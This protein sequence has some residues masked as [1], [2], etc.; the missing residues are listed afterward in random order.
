[1][2]TKVM[3]IAGDKLEGGSSRIDIGLGLELSDNGGI[4]PLLKLR[5]R[6]IVL[7]RTPAERPVAVV[8]VRREPLSTWPADSVGARC[9][10]AP[11]C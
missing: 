3:P 1:M 2:P 6:F 9:P 4:T 11:F 10:P 7:W 8:S 5:P